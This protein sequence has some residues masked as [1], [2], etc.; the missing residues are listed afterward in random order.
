MNQA[1]A[2][3]EQ[4][5]TTLRQ[6]IADLEAREAALLADLATLEAAIAAMRQWLRTHNKEGEGPCPVDC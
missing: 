4:R 3:H 6:A 2:V 1:L 5:V